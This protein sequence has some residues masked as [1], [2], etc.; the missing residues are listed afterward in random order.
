MVE[1]IFDKMASEAVYRWVQP[2]PIAQVGKDV[3]PLAVRPEYKVGGR[4]RKRL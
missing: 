1:N 3:K 2:K 4:Y